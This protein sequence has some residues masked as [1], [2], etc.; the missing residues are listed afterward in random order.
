MTMAESEVFAALGSD[1]QTRSE[2]YPKV[3]AN[4]QQSIA[5]D[6]STK[7]EDL[8]AGKRVPLRRWFS[9]TVRAGMAI[10]FAGSCVTT[11]VLA[12]MHIQGPSWKWP[13]WV[14]GSLAAW[15]LDWAAFYL[16]ALSIEKAFATSQHVIYYMHGSRRPL[17][18]FMAACS[19]LV[20]FS[21]LFAPFRIQGSLPVL[22]ALACIAI[23]AFGLLG[24]QIA[25]K[26][27]AAH[28]H[29]RGFFE[30]L[31]KALR[32]EYYLMALSKPRGARLGRKS[33]TEQ[34]Y[35]QNF[36]P[37]PSKTTKKLADTRLTREDPRLLHSLDA[38]ERHVRSHRLKLVFDRCNDVNDVASAKRLAFYI[39]WNV[40]ADKSREWLLR[41]DLEHFL[42]DDEVDGAFMLLDPDGDGRPTWEECRAAVIQVFDRRRHLSA[43]LKDTD[44]IMGTLH[45]I[46]IGL[47]QVVEFFIFLLVWRVDVVHVWLTFSSIALA[48][49]FVF[50][51]SIKTAYENMM[52]VFFIHPYDV[53]DR[54]IFDDKVYTVHKIK[55]ST[56]ILEEDSG[57]RVWFPNN[58]M[59]LLPIY[60]QTR[61]E[62][63]R[64]SFA[65]LM[66]FNTPAS[67]FDD[68]Q[69]RT[70][71]YI[72]GNSKDF[73]GECRCVTTAAIDPLKLRLTLSVT[74]SFNASQSG[75]LSTVRHGLI[76]TITSAL[77]Q[78]GAQ[79]S[80]PQQIAAGGKANTV[81]KQPR[82]L[83]EGDGE[84][85]HEDDTSE[86]P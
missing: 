16:L 73:Q 25:T 4:W 58:R 53:G 83:D 82:A 21:G 30:R 2:A 39:F 85:D 3:Y 20:I 54:L 5:V 6:L 44:S 43:S 80:E 10:L 40:I 70:S 81:T 31:Q 51:T 17:E 36:K 61:A 38:V 56:T 71:A 45:S 26:V 19:S 33:W 15:A 50:G 22:K 68:V 55:L 35:L 34:T 28:F 66:D 67:I 59:S 62:V 9:W 27:L 72:R 18:R 52:F 47:F 48:F 46:V 7:D 42:P 77:S 24:A 23:A 64:E 63:V 29:R 49:T 69:D 74:Y 32:D 75:R 76:L 1:N 14:A 78:A 65:Y 37:K 84:H 8:L 11:A 41:S 86:T 60:N 13:A 79:Y 12:S 57:V